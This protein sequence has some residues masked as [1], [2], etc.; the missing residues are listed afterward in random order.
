MNLGQAIAPNTV[1]F[2]I[3]NRAQVI[4]VA[5]VYEED[6]G[7]VKTGQEAKVKVLSYPQKRF[8]GKVIL[9][10]PNLDSLTRTVNIQILL[11]NQQGLLKPGMFTRVYLRLAQKAEALT[12]PNSAILEANNEKFVFKRQGNAYERVVVKTGLSDETYT[13]I[14]AGLAAGDEVVMQGNRQLYTLWLTGGNKTQST[15]DSP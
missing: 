8:T 11:D 10:E 2:H 5:K 9:I 7:K 14:T 1:L 3:S 4:T 13:E 6:L 12:I 15:K